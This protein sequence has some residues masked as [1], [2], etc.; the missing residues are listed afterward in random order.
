[1][2]ATKEITIYKWEELSQTAQ[3]RARDWYIQGLDFEWWDS[4]YEMCIDDGYEKGFVIDKINFSGFYSQGDGAR[5][6]GKVDVGAWL[7]AHAPDCIGV[8]ALIALINT[9]YLPK[10]VQVGSFNSHYCHE[11]TMDVSELQDVDERLIY[12]DQ[13]DE[14]ELEV[15]TIEGQGIFDGMTLVNIRDLINTDEANP[16]R[17]TNL[18]AL[19][20]DIEESCKNYATEIYNRLREEYEYLCSEE[21]MQEHFE[22]NDYHFTE[23]GALA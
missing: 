6:I 17:L 5:W 10:H 22:A 19:D 1:M 13:I 7:K 9:D 21:V 3:Q 16:Y 15:E 23:E 18:A 20:H 4:V 12:G 14:M 11:N 2:P 8:S